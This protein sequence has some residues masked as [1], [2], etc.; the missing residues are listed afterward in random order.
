M[1]LAIIGDE[2]DQDL[3]KVINIVKEKSFSGVEIRSVW[4]TRPDELDKIQ[5][6]KIKKEIKDSNLL[7]AGFDSPVFK[8]ELPRTTEQLQEAR[9]NFLK[10]V[11]QAR[12]LNAGFI[13]VFTFYRVGEANPRLAGRVLQ[14]IIGDIIPDDIGIYIET[15]MRTNTPTI[16]HMLSMLDV[17]ASDQLGVV[18]DPGNSVYAGAIKKPF[19][20]EYKE[21]KDVIKHI[22]IKDPKGQQEYVRL[23]DGDIPWLDILRNLKEDNYTGW[24]S[25]ETHWR[26]G[27]VL[28]QEIRDNPWYDQFSDGGYAASVQCMD[29]IKKYMEVI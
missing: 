17:I 14:E 13:R 1:K 18:W 8:T 9:E 12:L 25:L 29:K 4:N 16:Q 22:H 15:G 10:A 28:S 3:S 6:K 11:E 27:K 20:S 5:I 21:G 2:I 7:I 23:G 19:P 26:I 24:L